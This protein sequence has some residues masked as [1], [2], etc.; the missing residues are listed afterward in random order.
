MVGR[1]TTGPESST[2]HQL[3]IY[4]HK[5]QIRYRLHVLET[6]EK[7]TLFD[8]LGFRLSLL[9]C[10]ALRLPPSS[11][12]SCHGELNDMRAN[13]SPLATHDSTWA[14]GQR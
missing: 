2:Q 12:E 3:P 6:S 9:S 8:I 1:R 11:E 4:Y 10:Y 7:R 14:K 5:C 13:P